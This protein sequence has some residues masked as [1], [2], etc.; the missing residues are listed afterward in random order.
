MRLS[1]YD[2]MAAASSFGVEGIMVGPEDLDK[3]D[4]L[5]AKYPGPE[6]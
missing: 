1:D 5:E 3:E 2:A 4:E 6:K